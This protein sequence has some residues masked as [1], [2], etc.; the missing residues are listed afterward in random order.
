MLPSS[1]SCFYN[2]LKILCNTGQ[3]HPAGTVGFASLTK[4]RAVSQYGMGV[5]PSN[6]VTT[7]SEINSG[8]EPYTAICMR[9]FAKS[10]LTRRS[11]HGAGLAQP[12]RC[13]PAAHPACDALH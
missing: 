10:M 1:V 13:A 12:H 5:V 7:C 9:T 8:A 2:K 11:S 6:D 3:Q 4:S